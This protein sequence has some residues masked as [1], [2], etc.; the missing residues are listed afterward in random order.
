MLSKNVLLQW[1]LLILGSPLLFSQIQPDA[2]EKLYG[3]G[4]QAYPAGIIA[5][6][7]H[8][9]FLSENTSLLFRLG[10]NLTDRQDF[11]DENDSEKGGGFGASI[12]Y[13][14]HIPLNRNA[15]VFGLHT[16]LWN[17]WI[18]WDNPST[19]ARPLSGTTYILVFQPWLEGGYL[20][21][22]KP[23]RST[24]GISVGFGREINVISNGREVAQ[25][26]IGS[27]IIR[28]QF[29]L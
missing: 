20:F 29:S 22:R 11:S 2:L 15:L 1:T 8:E 6:L 12:G 26:W 5:T 14:K 17:L 16:D 28:Y 18:D 13:R 19:T 25:D 9:R 24:L 7:D 21:K 27:L 23:S 10:A 4:L 3:I